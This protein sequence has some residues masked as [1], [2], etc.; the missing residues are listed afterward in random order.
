M[1]SYFARNRFWREKQE[2]ITKSEGL[3]PNDAERANRLC[4]KMLEICAECN[5]LDNGTTLHEFVRA[6]TPSSPD[7]SFLDMPRN[8][9]DTGKVGKRKD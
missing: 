8:V 7:D 9:L 3:D 6:F 4:S 5:G 1:E 2:S